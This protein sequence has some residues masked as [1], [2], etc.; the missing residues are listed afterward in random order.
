VLIF[1][2]GAADPAA[3]AA[4]SE[5]NFSLLGAALCVGSWLCPWASATALRIAME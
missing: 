2:V 5:A 1:G 3:T 4:W